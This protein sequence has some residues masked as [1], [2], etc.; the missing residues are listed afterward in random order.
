MRIIKTS[1]NFGLWVRSSNAWTYFSRCRNQGSV[2]TTIIL[3][4]SAHGIHVGLHD[5][6]EESDIRHDMV[7]NT[8]LSIPSMRYSSIQEIAESAGCTVDREADGDYLTITFGIEDRGEV[9]L[10]QATRLR[11]TGSAADDLVGIGLAPDVQAANRILAWA[12]ARPT[13][14]GWDEPGQTFEVGGHPVPRTA[15]LAAFAG[16]KAAGEP[17]GYCWT[18]GS[19]RAASQALLGRS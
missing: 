19:Y 15:V 8:G 14:I 6:E 1:F 11:T 2:K 3:H 7:T 10:I 13:K 4:N 12:S 17:S 5:P 16:G 18:E 9:S